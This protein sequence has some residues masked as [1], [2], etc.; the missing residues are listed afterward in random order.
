MCAEGPGRA[1]SNT[2]VL[3][4]GK[5]TVRLPYCKLEKIAKRRS[6]FRRWINPAIYLPNN[7]FTPT[8]VNWR[9]TLRARDQGCGG[10]GRL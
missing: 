8:V 1:L 2:L 6:S 7:H 3:P 4:S 9:L 10:S 5:V